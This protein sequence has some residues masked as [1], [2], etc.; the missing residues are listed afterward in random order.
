MT[1]QSLQDIGCE[2]GLQL[3]LWWPAHERYE[4]QAWKVCTS[5]FSNS[6]GIETTGGNNRRVIAQ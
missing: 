1:I 2:R 4:L 3:L 6:V 5:Y